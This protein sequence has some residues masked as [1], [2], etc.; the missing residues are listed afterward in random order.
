MDEVL[1]MKVC[2]L[3]TEY[4]PFHEGH[5]K[6]IKQA[7]RLS[8]ADVYIV[9]MSPNFVQRGEPSIECKQKR[10]NDALENGIDIIVEIPTIYAVESADIFAYAALHLLN[11]LGANNIVF[12]TESGNTKTFTSKF[13]AKAFSSPRMDEVIQEYLEQGYS[14]PKAK[15]EAS[16][17][18][19]DFYLENPND[20][21]GY[22]YLKII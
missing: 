7:K 8:K 20:I 11:D 5:I 16:K 15:A 6:H 9:A 1:I 21:L 2:G 14:Y 17:I 19:N 3:V 4:N 13:K 10:V 22:S 18:I 12:G